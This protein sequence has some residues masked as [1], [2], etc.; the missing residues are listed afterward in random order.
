M[1]NDLMSSALSGLRPWI[2]WP[3]QGLG[4]LSALQEGPVVEEVEMELGS[5]MA[6]LESEGDSGCTSILS[7]CVTLD[8][9]LPFSKHHSFQL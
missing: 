1:G 6:W 7:P 4:P 3:S 5:G 2:R 9:S 8:G